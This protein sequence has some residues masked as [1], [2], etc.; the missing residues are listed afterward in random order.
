MSILVTAFYQDSRGRFSILLKEDKK[1][2]MKVAKEMYEKLGL[3]GRKMN[4]SKSEF[5]IEIDLTA[6]NMQVGQRVRM[7]LLENVANVLK[8]P[9]KIHF[10][11]SK[12]ASTRLNDLLYTLKIQPQLEDL[13]ISTTEHDVSVPEIRIA[14]D[15]LPKVD[16]LEELGLWL[17]AL[18]CDANIVNGTRV[19]P[20]IS[21]CQ[22]PD[23]GEKH[24][25]HSQLT[26]KDSIIPSLSIAELLEAL[27]REEG[28]WTNLILTGTDQRGGGFSFYLDKALNFVF[29]NV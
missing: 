11:C 14:T 15:R 28:D 13:A 4:K 23:G 29:C 24:L 2:I 19:D 18:T 17:G 9:L 7:R 21:T 16:E 5:I 1:I 10:A 22:L 27:T 20:F 6:S 3:E 25:F 12:T 8:M 26:I